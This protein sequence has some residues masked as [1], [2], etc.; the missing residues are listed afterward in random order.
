MMESIMV[1]RQALADVASYCGNGLREH[2][3]QS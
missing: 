3:E 1:A 2:M